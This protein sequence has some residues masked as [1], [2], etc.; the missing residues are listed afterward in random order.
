MKDKCSKCGKPLFVEGEYCNNTLNDD[1]LLTVSI[2][3]GKSAT[4]RRMAGKYAPGYYTFCAE[5]VLDSALLTAIVAG[6]DS[7]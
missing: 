5:C 7:R 3:V 1:G 6:E 4:H 2:L